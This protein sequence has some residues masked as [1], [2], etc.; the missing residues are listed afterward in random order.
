MHEIFTPTEKEL[1]KAFAIIE[2]IKAE[3]RGSGV[4][5]LNGKMIDKPVVELQSL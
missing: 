5:A 4:M 2:A 1:E 3:S